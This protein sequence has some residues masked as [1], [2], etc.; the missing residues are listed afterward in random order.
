MKIIGVTA[1]PTGIA[2]TYMAAMRLTNVAKAEHHEIKVETQ[3]AMGI[4]H[5]LT[6]KDIHAAD[7]AIIAADI[8]ISGEER[9]ANIPVLRVPTLEV[10]NDP[11]GVL[12][13]ALLQ[14]S[15]AG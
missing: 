13:R 15:A 1:C 7:I 11:Q 14:V 5:T 12:T 8:P 3:G 6:T 10:I 4:E 9:F 2:H